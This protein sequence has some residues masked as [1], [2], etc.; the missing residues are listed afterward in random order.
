MREKRSGTKPASRRKTTPRAKSRA[1]SKAQG[2]DW[3]RVDATTDA[4]IAAQVRRNPDDVEFTEEMFA[5][6]QWVMP[7]RKVPISFRVDPDVL[8]FFKNGGDGYQSRMNAVLRG[9]MRGH[10]RKAR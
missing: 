6:A 4:E 5:A 9:Y 10:K 7:E 1:R 8:A 3:R 2:I